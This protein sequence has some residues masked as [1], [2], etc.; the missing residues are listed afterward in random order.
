MLSLYSRQISFKIPEYCRT[1]D[2]K[3]ITSNCFNL[4]HAFDEV[5]AF[6]KLPNINSIQIVTLGYRE[7]VNLA[8]IRTFTEM[9]SHEERV[10]MQIKEAQEKAAK[11]AM[12]EKA[13]ELKRQQR[14][15]LTRGLKIG[16]SGFSSATGISSSSTPLTAVQEPAAVVNK[17]SA[18]S[19]TIGSGK[20]MK[21]GTKTRNEDEFLS[22]LAK[23]GQAI[24][25]VE[26]ATVC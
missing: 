15:A 5:C 14:E 21:L 13:K 18:P 6:Y 23:E 17:P 10:F 25:P 2:E 16:G 1:I 22:Q 3:E 11:D 24:A 26:R 19:R 8:Q 12:A 9:D 4:I 7:S 20:A